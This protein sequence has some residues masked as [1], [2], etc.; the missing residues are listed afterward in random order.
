MTK[1]KIIVGLLFL[2][3]N[4]TS[5]KCDNTGLKIII[6]HNN[7][8]EKVLLTDKEI[9]GYDWGLHRIFIKETYIDELMNIEIDDGDEFNLYVGEILICTGSFINAADSF[10]KSLEPV[11]FFSPDNR[12]FIPR[13]LSFRIM[14][15]DCS[16]EDNPLNNDVLFGFLK[17]K[18]ILLD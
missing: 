14:C 8:D 6:V 11:I 10:F 12:L 1:L 5:A 15:Y 7:G 9:M 2:I 18:N 17:D 3:I 13:E 4:C 16:E